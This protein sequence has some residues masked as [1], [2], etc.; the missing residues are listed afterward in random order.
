MIAYV[1]GFPRGAVVFLYPYLI[2]NTHSA[3]E[4]RLC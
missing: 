4:I 1:F 3:S 2:N